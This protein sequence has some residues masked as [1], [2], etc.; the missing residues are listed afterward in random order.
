MVWEQNCSGCEPNPKN[1]D[2]LCGLLHYSMC[3]SQPPLKQTNKQ[4]KGWPNPM[5]SHLMCD[6]KSCG[7]SFLL[8]L[9]YYSAYSQN[10]PKCAIKMDVTPSNIN[11]LCL[12]CN[13]FLLA[14]SQNFCIYNFYG[15]D[16]FNFLNKQ[17]NL[18]FEEIVANFL[19]HMHQNSTILRFCWIPWDFTNLILQD[20]KNVG[21]GQP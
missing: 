17:D 1:W 2:A 10:F 6:I 19:P 21:F 3:L 11:W 14:S 20:W 9:C 8:N 13:M 12:F 5:G 15:C 4:T 7:I 18:I 16:S